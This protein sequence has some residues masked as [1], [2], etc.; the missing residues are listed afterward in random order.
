MPPKQVDDS[1][2]KIVD[3]QRPVERRLLI[4]IL[5]V[6]VST[7]R[8]Q[9]FRGFDPFRVL[10]SEIPTAMLRVRPFAGQMQ[11]CFATSIPRIHLAAEC[12]QN[13]DHRSPVV[14]ECRGCM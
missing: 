4:L 10:R 12:D 14:T 13:L 11:R 5:G 3:R 7:V 2:V 8:D 6:H 1:F 9:S